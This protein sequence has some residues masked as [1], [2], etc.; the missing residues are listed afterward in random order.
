MLI[1]IFFSA[2]IYNVLTHEF[3]RI[4]RIEQLKRQGLPFGDDILRHGIRIIPPH[5]EVIQNAKERLLAI[6]GIVN[7]GIFGFSG[8]AGYFLAGR[9]LRPIKE[10]VDE[11]NRFITDASHELRTP[12]TSIKTETE[13]NLRDRK[14][15]KDVKKIMKSNLEDINNL[16]TLSDNLIRLTQYQRSNGNIVLVETSLKKIAD[17]A[18]KKVAN[19]AKHK[20][21]TMNNKIQN[22][23]IVGDRQSLLEAF[24]IFLDNAIK[25][26]P[27]NTSVMLD[28]KI[29]NYSVVVN[30][31][32]EGIGID[33]KEIPHIFERFYRV[34][35]S[36]TKTSV[37]GFG[38]GLSIAKQIIDKH[39]GKISV[40]SGVGKGTTFSVQL[41]KR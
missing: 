10:M 4:L 35:K 26:S 6:L 24:V 3:N 7:L 40:E 33:K 28:S 11:Q 36:R 37:E 17:K 19:L 5:P 27:K 1:S 8:I 38:L 31:K 2:V 30:I 20:K 25:Y 16:Q 34:D 29:N 22:C 12:I 15:S 14:I 21:I 39:N 41:P 23:T 9:T 13:V 18:C 32:D